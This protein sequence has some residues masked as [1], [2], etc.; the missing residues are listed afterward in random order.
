MSKTLVGRDANFH[1]DWRAHA[2]TEEAAIILFCSTT[3]PSPC[4]TRAFGA[5]SSSSG[6]RARRSSSSPCS[7]DSGGGVRALVLAERGEVLRVP[8]SRGSE[9][10]ILLL[11]PKREEAVAIPEPLR[12]GSSQGRRRIAAA[13]SRPRSRPPTPPPAPRGPARAARRIWTTSRVVE[14]DF[15]G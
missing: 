15:K 9:A 4:S 10:P 11:Q 1:D 14:N 13:D 7:S 3:M 5:T 12:R 8:L 6:S 2:A